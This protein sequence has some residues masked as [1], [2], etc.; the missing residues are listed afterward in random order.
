MLY[1]FIQTWLWILGA[2]LFGLI[3]G[4]LIWGK[5]SSPENASLEELKSQLTECRSN[6]AKLEAISKAR[7]E[8]RELNARTA[9]EVPS[10]S[11][12][13]FRGDERRD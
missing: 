3:V 5:N 10:D 7:E 11:H 2:G 6:Y 4:W 12:A 13:T 1:L 8:N 9:I